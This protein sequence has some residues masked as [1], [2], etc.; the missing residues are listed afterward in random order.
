MG[1]RSTLMYLPHSLSTVVFV[2][3]EWQ[4]AGHEAMHKPLMKAIRSVVLEQ[5]NWKQE[6]Y[7][8]VRQYRAT[9][10][11]STK[12]SPHLLLLGWEPGT[13][14]SC[15]STKDTHDNRA[16]RA[17][18]RVNDNQAK[19]CQKTY[20]DKRNRAAHN[21]LQVGDTVLM[22][23]DSVHSATNPWSSQIYKARLSPQPMTARRFVAILLASK[24]CLIHFQFLKIRWVGEKAQ[25]PQRRQR[26]LH[27][28]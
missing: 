2:I 3:G 14:L 18:A 1:H 9:P 7:Q 17:A 13:K 15:I 24:R 22:R 19:L 6:M 5:K 20:A 4:S 10:H 8:F 16:V 11:M 25:L 21:D 26:R 23:N 27:Q 12:F 28:L